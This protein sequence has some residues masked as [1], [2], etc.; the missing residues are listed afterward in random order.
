MSNQRIIVDTSIWIEYFKNNK[1]YVAFIE[2]N[3]NL[4]N[5]LI[6][7]PIISELL[8][9]IKGSREYDMLSRSIAAIPYIECI[10]EDWIETG[11]VLY[12]LRGRGIMVPLTD[13][14]IATV[15]IRKDASVLTLD[16]HF[17]DISS[18]TNLELC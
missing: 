16:E 14:L 2:K 4:E 7:G 8:H 11:K 17:K 15:A 13:A 6:T 3:L 1:K 10:Y 5:I 18:V 9:G 12:N